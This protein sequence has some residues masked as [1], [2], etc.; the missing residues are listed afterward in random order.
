MPFGEAKA[1]P[2]IEAMPWSCSLCGLST[3]STFCVVHVI[4]AALQLLVQPLAK[5]GSA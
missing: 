2:M 3:S 5:Q 4:V 1:A